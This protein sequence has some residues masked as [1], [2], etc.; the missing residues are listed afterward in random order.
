MNGRFLRRLSI[1]TVMAWMAAAIGPAVVPHAQ[2]FD[3]A[4]SDD[5]WGG[6][7]APDN[8][9]DTRKTSGD[10]HC[11]VCHLQRAARE[12]IAEPPRALAG[13]N[14]SVDI[15]HASWHTPGINAVERTPAR[16]P[17]AASL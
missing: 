7:Q 5:A 17:P 1:V 14:L 4:C 15:A 3:L 13:P 12:A 2:T 11:L 8:I 6:Q 10:D 16:A 9:Q